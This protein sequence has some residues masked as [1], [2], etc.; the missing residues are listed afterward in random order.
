MA[1]SR[2]GLPL[3]VQDSSPFE[4]VARRMRTARKWRDDGVGRAF[5]SMMN[6][7]ALDLRLD[8]CTDHESHLPLVA[9]GLWLVACG[10][11]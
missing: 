1:Q 11:S 5:P 4:V 6:M 3:D 10:L 7:S 9:C 8:T 2:Q